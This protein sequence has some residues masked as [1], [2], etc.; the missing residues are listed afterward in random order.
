MERGDKEQSEGSFCIAA[1]HMASVLIR[2]DFI[3]LSVL[4]HSFVNVTSAAILLCF[5]PR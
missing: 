1:D 2:S 5:F 3:T 4:P